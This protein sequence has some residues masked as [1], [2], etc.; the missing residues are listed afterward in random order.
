MTPFLSPDGPSSAVSP[1]GSD[2]RR[3]VVVGNGASLLDSRRGELIDSFDVVVRF[4]L[5]KTGKFSRDV[6]SKTNVWFSNRDA[7]SATIRAMLSRHRFDEI[8][9]HTWRN[10]RA[11]VESFRAEVDELGLP[12]PVHEVEKSHL[13]DMRTF[14]GRRYPMFSTGAIGVWLLLT[15]YREVT[16]TGFD[17]W[18]MPEKLH[19]GDNQ[20]FSYHRSKGHQPKLEKMFFDKLADEGKL[21]FLEDGGD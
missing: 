11:A 5:F 19:Y 18:H 4:N 3:V 21:R 9:V 16:L 1:C 10:T 17:W 6:G 15:R 13:A 7:G 12:I 2:P 20:R 8:H 14:L